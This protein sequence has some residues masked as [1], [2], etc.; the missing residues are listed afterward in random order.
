MTLGNSFLFS[1]GTRRCDRGD[2]K[3]GQWDSLDVNVVVPRVGVQQIEITVD[4]SKALFIKKKTV[5]ANGNV[6]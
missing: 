6:A 2:S 1:T 3:S 4:S 5:P